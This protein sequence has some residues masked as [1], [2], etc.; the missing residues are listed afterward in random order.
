MQV[1]LAIPVTIVFVQAW[2]PPLD[3]AYKLN[4][5]A[6]VFANTNSSSLVPLFKMIREMLWPLSLLEDL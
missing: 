1:Q 2:R 4:F 6:A 3:L 5:D